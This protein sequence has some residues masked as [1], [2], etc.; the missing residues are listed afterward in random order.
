[1]SY[2]IA[3][4]SKR[5]VN[6]KFNDEFFHSEY[7]KCTLRDLGEILGEPQESASEYLDARGWL[8]Q[9]GSL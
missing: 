3:S 6:Y 9:A 8:A 4:N 2:Q 1:M 7:L 5:K